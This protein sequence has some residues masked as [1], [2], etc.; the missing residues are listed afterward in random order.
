[1]IIREVTKAT[2]HDFSSPKLHF[3]DSIFEK[4][5][6]IFSLLAGGVYQFWFA[7]NHAILSSRKKT[8]LT[9]GH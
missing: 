6:K 7:F 4:I 3:S 8:R 9:K 5:L 1:M 2:E